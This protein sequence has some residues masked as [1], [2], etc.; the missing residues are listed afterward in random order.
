MKEKSQLDQEWEKVASDMLRSELEAHGLNMN[1]L[2]KK[3]ADNGSDISHKAVRSKIARGGF[4]AGFFLQCLAAI[5]SSRVKLD[6]G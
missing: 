2:R 3:L 5:G 1:D 6:K 4:S